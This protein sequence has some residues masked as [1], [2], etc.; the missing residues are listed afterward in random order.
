MLKNK[1]IFQIWWIGF[2]SYFFFFTLL[3]SGL[4]LFLVGNAWKGSQFTLSAFLLLGISLISN[5]QNKLRKIVMS[6]KL[7]F[8][9][10]L[11]YSFAFLLLFLGII[12]KFI[13]MILT[14]S[15]LLARGEY[16]WLVQV[17]GY[18]GLLYAIIFLGLTIYF[19]N[20]AD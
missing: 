5:V 2:I 8:A 11:F 20:Y 16:F 9:N 1:K 4:Q 18:G 3:T 10:S 6:V 15:S 14:P 13:P 7:N 19:L 12:T 17:S